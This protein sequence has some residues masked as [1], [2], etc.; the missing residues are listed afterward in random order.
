MGRH[1]DDFQGFMG[2]MLPPLNDG[3][4]SSGAP[5]SGVITGKGTSIFGEYRPGSGRYHGGVDINYGPGTSGG[6]PP[7]FSPIK[8][9]VVGFDPNN[10]AVVIRDEDGYDHV[11]MHFNKSPKV[12]INA[13]VNPG[14]HLGD[15]GDFV[16]GKNNGQP[17]VHYEIRIE[18]DGQRY[19]VD[20]VQFHDGKPLDEIG[21]MGDQRAG[22]LDMSGNPALRDSLRQRQ[23]REATARREREERD[24]AQPQ[25]PAPGEDRQPDEGRRGGS[26]GSEDKEAA[27]MA[28]DA[29]WES[30]APGRAPLRPG[31]RLGQ[32]PGQP[33]MPPQQGPERPLPDAPNPTERHPGEAF[34]R[35]EREMLRKP[36]EIELHGRNALDRGANNPSGPLSLAEQPLPRPI[37]LLTDPLS[38]E[39]DPDGLEREAWEQW[40][41]GLPGGAA[42]V[43]GSLLPA[44]MPRL[45]T[46]TE[47]PRRTRP[48]GYVDAFP[49]PDEA[50]GA[51]FPERRDQN[52]A[53]PGLPGASEEMSTLD[54]VKETFR[55]AAEGASETPRPK[56]PAWFKPSNPE[57]LTTE[58]Y[59]WEIFNPKAAKQ[60]RW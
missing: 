25:P 13:E 54:F 26:G 11:F 57:E 6:N 24:K 23:E 43:D 39:D 15:M 22:P 30:T 31:Q 44:S 40:R 33:D 55:L 27:R 48:P 14:D 21:I 47:P 4:G 49:E 28:Q 5:R 2:S 12:D 10:N 1:K 8:G 19:K 17:H 59:I 51:F 9:K 56:R 42:V 18:V 45:R 34:L 46:P 58:E 52:R 7:V 50:G 20:P 41:R 29:A 32:R 36:P 60:S 16:N 37:N 38:P 3:H 35:E 53:S